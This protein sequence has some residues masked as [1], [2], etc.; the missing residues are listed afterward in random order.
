MQANGDRE[1]QLTTSPYPAIFPDFSPD[2]R[3]VAYQANDGGPAG[4]DIYVVSA[5][6]G[7]ARRFTGAPGNDE[8]PVFSPDG[9]TI[10]FTSQRKGGA[11]IW[12]MNASDGRNQRALTSDRR[13]KFELDWRP[14][15]Q[16]IAYAAGGDIWVMNADGSRQVNLTRSPAR[17]NG[18]AWSP[19][20][21]RIAYIQRDGAKRRIWVMNADGSGRRPVGGTGAHLV[22]A[23]QPRP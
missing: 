5:R 1:R 20:G 14:D 17:E 19:D 2:G 13:V 10:A 12:L 21:R 15:G 3:R 9:K 7:K 22:P 6:G 4:E 8:Y 23:W 18:V 11:Q 16:R